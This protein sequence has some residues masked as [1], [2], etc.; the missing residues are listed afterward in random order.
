MICSGV[1]HGILSL[2]AEM[3]SLSEMLNITEIYPEVLVFDGGLPPPDGDVGEDNYIDILSEPSGRSHVT[4]PESQFNPQF[5]PDELDWA[6]LR[7]TDLFDG[8]EPP[9][10]PYPP[11]AF[12]KLVP[13][14]YVPSQLNIEA[15]PTDPTTNVT[16][17]T[18]VLK[19]VPLTVLPGQGDVFRRYAAKWLFNRGPEGLKTSVRG[20]SDARALIHGFG[21][22]NLTGLPVEGTFYVGAKHA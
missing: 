8:D 14:D 7:G 5:S 12:A 1:I 9:S 4:V 3:Q 21:A 19:D 16:V 15:S 17:L 18:A 13:P 11:N 2:P 20:H 10:I 22:L 6:N